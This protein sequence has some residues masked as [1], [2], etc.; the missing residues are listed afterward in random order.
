MQNQKLSGDELEHILTDEK[1]DP[2]FLLQ[3]DDPHVIKQIISSCVG[4]RNFVRGFKSTKK[5]HSR[6]FRFFSEETKSA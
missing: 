6:F 3:Q 1:F 5:G 4:F 2:T